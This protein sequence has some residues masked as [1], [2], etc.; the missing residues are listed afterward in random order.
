[1]A[2]IIYLHNR[3]TWADL[4]LWGKD[5]R[6]PLRSIPLVPNYDDCYK[7]ISNQATPLLCLS[8]VFVAMFQKEI[9]FT[10]AMLQWTDRQLMPYT[11]VLDD[12]K[13]GLIK[14]AS[15]GYSIQVLISECLQDLGQRAEPM[16][17]GLSLYESYLAATAEGVTWAAFYREVH[18]QSTLVLTG[19]FPVP[20]STK[21]TFALPR[22]A[23][24]L[25]KPLRP[26]RLKPAY[27]TDLLQ[28]IQALVLWC[29]SCTPLERPREYL[30]LRPKLKSHTKWKFLFDEMIHEDVSYGRGR[31]FKMAVSIPPAIKQLLQ[32][33]ISYQ[34]RLV[35]PEEQAHTLRLALAASPEVNTKVQPTAVEQDDIEILEAQLLALVKKVNEMKNKK[36]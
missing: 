2:Y 8:T 10:D 28:A 29:N 36:K 12:H 33:G 35:Q 5:K 7:Q 34:G 9:S 19:L 23:P 32:Y 15:V 27:I 6:T 30:S 18:N 24:K 17:V 4:L 3:Q 1:M 20:E 14:D 21:T 11:P 13:I 26:Q 16:D 25:L 22:N 31:P